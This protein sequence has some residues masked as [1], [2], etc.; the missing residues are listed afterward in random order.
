MRAIG[1]GRAHQA[2]ATNR[3]LEVMS[4]LTFRIP[5]YVRLHPP[6]LTSFF[7]QIPKAS[8]APKHSLH[9]KKVWV[10]FGYKSPLK[11]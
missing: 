1:G 4:S 5:Q 10:V 6:S 7:W 2:P 8:Q 11:V 3:L 9:S